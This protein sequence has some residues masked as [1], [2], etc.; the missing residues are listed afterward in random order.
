MDTA[1]WDVLAKN[2]QVQARLLYTLVSKYAKINDRQ[3]FEK[4]SSSNIFELG[5]WAVRPTRAKTTK[6]PIG[7]SEFL[8]FLSINKTIPRSIL[9]KYTLDEIEQLNKSIIKKVK[10]TVPLPPF[11]ETL[12]P[13]K[14]V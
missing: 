1:K 3:E 9:S 2:Y 6:A 14:R 12:F 5:Q 13:T 7:W 4:S 10:L 11:F 8:H